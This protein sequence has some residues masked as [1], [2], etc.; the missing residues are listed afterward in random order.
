MGVCGRRKVETT[1]EDG[2]ASVAHLYL[3]IEGQQLR[4]ETKREAGIVAVQYF[5]G[6]P[7][8]NQLHPLTPLHLTRGNTYPIKML[9]QHGLLL[10][11]EVPGPW[12][13]PIL[14][15]P[16]NGGTVLTV[17]PVCL[18]GKNVC[19]MNI[20]VGIL[21]LQR[22]HL[23]PSHSSKPVTVVSLILTAHPYHERKI[24]EVDKADIS[25]MTR[26]HGRGCPMVC[27]TGCHT[28]NTV[29]AGRIAQ[30]IDLVRIDIIMRNHGTD[31]LQVHCVD[32]FLTPHIPCVP[33][34]TG[35][36][37][38]TL[39]WAVEKLLVTPLPVVHFSRHATAS[40]KGYPEATPIGRL[41]AIDCP[42]EGH[43][44][45]VVKDHT[46]ADD[47]IR[48]TVHRIVPL[49]VYTFILLSHAAKRC[50]EGKDL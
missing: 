14:R 3:A 6:L 31:D 35:S 36:H 11:Y 23:S 4:G 49:T 40:M 41:L 39:L 50:C 12:I 7:R 5:Y 45:I 13:S 33:R 2:L 19:L 27:H 1:F 42:E 46:V 24:A 17:H 8:D 16:G 15:Q 37:I 10:P 38:D 28:P 25:R 30:N 21:C 44:E 47:S 43:T 22:I 20:S 48:G 32:R 9:L 34:S 18:V 29:T 26:H